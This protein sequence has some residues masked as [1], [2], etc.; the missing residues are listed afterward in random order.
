MNLNFKRMLEL[1]K[2]TLGHDGRRWV[3]R[4][5][6]VNDADWSFR[7]EIYH[8]YGYSKDESTGYKVIACNY[9]IA[10]DELVVVTQEE[11]NCRVEGYLDHESIGEEEVM[12]SDYSDEE[13]EERC[14]EL[15]KQA[16]PLAVEKLSE[17]ILVIDDES[18]WDRVED[19]CFRWNA[20]QLFFNM[21]VCH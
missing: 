2:P 8:H 10:D 21:E 11:F 3:I 14:S 15:R 17:K 6:Y 18:F 16:R 19:C 4:F 13:A 1:D 7:V 9:Q 12:L 20:M 5:P